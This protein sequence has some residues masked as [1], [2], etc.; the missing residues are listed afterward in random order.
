MPLEKKGSI[1]K[2][3]DWLY[4]SECV[5]KA[6]PIFHGLQANAMLNW[7]YYG[8]MIP[9]YRFH[10]QQSPE[11]I[12]AAAFATGYTVPGSY[13]SGTLLTSFRFNAGRFWVT[14]FP[15]LAELGKHPVADRM[16]LNMIQYAASTMPQNLQALPSDFDQHLKAIGFV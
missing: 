3:Y 15:I 5:A 8:P 4:H 10:D 16:L 11:E 7:Y 9:Q 2:F 12:V 6:H 13:A 14:A 1:T